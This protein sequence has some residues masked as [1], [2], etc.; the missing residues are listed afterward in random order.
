MKIKIKAGSSVYCRRDNTNDGW[1]NF[2]TPRDLIYDE[3]ER[4]HSFTSP[5]QYYEFKMPPNDKNYDRLCVSRTTDQ[6]DNNAEI[7]LIDE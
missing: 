5:D 6:D 1:D 7:E 2:I 3:A 4:D